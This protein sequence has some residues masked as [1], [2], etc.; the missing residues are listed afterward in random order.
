MVISVVVFFVQ[1]LPF[2]VVNHVITTID[3][4]TTVDGGI[5]ISVLG[6]LKV[7]CVFFFF[8]TLIFSIFIQAD[9][10]PPHS[11]YQTFYLKQIGEKFFIL[12]DIFRLGLHHQ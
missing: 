2:Q 4:V 7:R 12:N 6:Q 3:S 10:D 9:N 11:F 5:M 8:L 1:G